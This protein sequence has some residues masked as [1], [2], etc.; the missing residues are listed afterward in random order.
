MP[1]L[2]TDIDKL[3]Y[4]IGEVAKKYKVNA[5][6]H[7]NDSVVNSCNLTVFGKA[8]KSFLLSSNSIV[9]VAIIQSFITHHHQYNIHD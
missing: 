2:K 5:V 4:S 6:D 7:T 9:A 1:K 3:F 8:L